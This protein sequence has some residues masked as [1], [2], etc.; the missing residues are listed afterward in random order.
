MTTTITTVQAPVTVG[1][2]TLVGRRWDVAPL[3]PWSGDASPEAV[4]YR[5]RNTGK[6][7]RC[8]VFLGVRYAEPPVGPLRWKD[9]VDYDY[10]AGTYQMDSLQN[11]PWQVY[12]EEGETRGRPEWGINNGAFSWPTMQPGG[13]QESEDCLFLDIYQ[14]RGQA[15]AGGWPVIFWMHGGGFQQNSRVAYHHRGH[16]IAAAKGCIVVCPGYRMSTFG[17]FYHP[18]ME[19]EPGYTGPNFM[20]SDVKS[21]LRWVNR[22]IASFGG[23]KNRVM[24]GG[25]SAGAVT[26]LAM[27][28]DASI[29]GLFACAWSS[30][31]GGTG[32]R[33][34]RD[35]TFY[36]EG[37]AKRCERFTKAA[38]AVAPSIRD[39]STP[40]RMLDVS[41]AAD[42]ELPALRKGLTPD[43]IMA[44][45]HTRKRLT[46][47]SLNAK[48]PAFANATSDNVF[49]WVG[50]GIA[51]YRPTD[52]AK[53]GRFT[54]P[55]VMAVAENESNLLSSF[56]D[57]PAA[58]PEAQEA[59]RRVASNLLRL[60]QYP[61]YEVW[62]AQP[63][64]PAAWISGG[65]WAEQR[66]KIYSHTTFHFAAWRIANAMSETASGTC[67]LA[68]WNFSTQG[69]A[70]HSS[71]VH[72][73]FGNVEWNASMSGAEAMVTV[74]T[75]QMAD[76]MMQS[77]ANFAA[78]GGNP[79]AAYAYAASAAEPTTTGD[80]NLFASPVT[81]T[82]VAYN[83]ATKLNHWNI[84]GQDD[85]SPGDNAAQCVHAAYLP[86]AWT[87]YKSYY[88]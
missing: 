56:P 57:E 14:P 38:T 30:S 10:P 31:G 27:M 58:T 7:R 75:L 37:F 86:G 47:A 19:N 43:H 88:G 5:N 67:Y 50:N 52:A 15:P 77:M 4:T 63:W 1:P 48:A 66:R 39:A 26:T 45:A 78:S 76:A 70:N 71:D 49:P 84:W 85:L 6:V 20:Y 53:A 36:S 44:F 22:N 3:M 87:D 18:D 13:T 80:W 24:V 62:A 46:R 12:S 59:K 42:G 41:I 28:E 60:I 8:N 40:A 82:M 61:Q 17:F 72:Y 16:R 54:K 33:M 74:R 29:S 64:V 21:A 51:Y 79:N 35:V 69:R 25:T 83:H 2:A 23:N 81:H 68:L 65:S 32:G 73:L 11:V 55:I 9:A 34:P